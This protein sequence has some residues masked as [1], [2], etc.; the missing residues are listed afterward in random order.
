MSTLRINKLVSWHIH[1]GI[2]NC[3]VRICLRSH[4]PH[5]RNAKPMLRVFKKKEKY[6]DLSGF[7]VDRL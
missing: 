7:E 3:Q 1:V 2:L 4:L 6:F 5:R